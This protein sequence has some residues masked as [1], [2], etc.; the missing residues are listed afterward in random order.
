MQTSKLQ[1]YIIRVL[2]FEVLCLPTRRLRVAVA[3]VLVPVYPDGAVL[4]VP[5][6]VLHVIAAR[7]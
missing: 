6:K 4:A 3:A 7:R 2:E 1:M 5:T